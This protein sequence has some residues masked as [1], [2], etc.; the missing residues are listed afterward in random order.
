ME[1]IRIETPYNKDE[2]R[3]ENKIRWIIFSKNYS[4]LLIYLS[5]FSVCMY[6]IGWVQTTD[7]EP[8]NFIFIFGIASIIMTC[9]LS[10]RLLY[11]LISYTRIIRIIADKFE[12][13]KMDCIYELNDESIKYWD[14]EKHMDFKWSMYSHY[15]FYKNYLVLFVN[16]SVTNTYL[17]K[18]GDT[19]FN[20]Y[21]KILEL[22]KTKLKF[23][24]I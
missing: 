4:R 13:E 10:L 11:S 24:K 1:N 23:K 6:F 12:K 5:F 20:Q 2:F 14:K 16:N 9:Y 21:E 18:K 3:K 15:S 7:E 22:V 17:F 19:E 8:F